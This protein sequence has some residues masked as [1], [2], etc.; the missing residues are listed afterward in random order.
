VELQ[1]KAWNTRQLGQQEQALQIDEN[2][3]P[4]PLLVLDKNP[5][6]QAL[7]M[8]IIVALFALLGLCALGLMWI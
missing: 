8:T 5:H 2:K 4:N 3:D 7:K 1:E 6:P